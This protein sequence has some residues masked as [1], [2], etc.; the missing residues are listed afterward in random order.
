L[1]VLDDG[2][3]QYKEFHD[4]FGHT[5]EPSLVDLTTLFNEIDIHHSGTLTLNELLKYFNH[6]SSLITTEEGKL[7]LGAISDSGNEDSIS[8][9]GQISSLLNYNILI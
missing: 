4:Y 7:F 6:Q 5:S 3:I 9:K 1:I 8:F 2:L